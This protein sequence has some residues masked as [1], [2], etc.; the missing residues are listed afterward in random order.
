MNDWANIKEGQRIELTASIGGTPT[1]FASVIEENTGDTLIIHMPSSTMAD[2]HL[3]EGTVLDV[4]VH[5]ENSLYKF[6]TRIKDRKMAGDMMLVL[7]RPGPGAVEKTKQRSYFRLNVSLPMQY[8]FMRDEVTPISNFKSGKILDLS[9]GGCLFESKKPIE[10]GSTVEVNLELSEDEEPVN[11]VAKIGF[12][13]KDNKSG[14][15]AMLNG[16]EFLVISEKERDKIIRFI[17]A[18]QRNLVKKGIMR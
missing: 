9:G 13:K 18:Q 7:F 11:A 10:K 17:F 1:Q 3:I 14:E 6:K 15:E 5:G 4:T 12:T 16:A 2:D 8:R